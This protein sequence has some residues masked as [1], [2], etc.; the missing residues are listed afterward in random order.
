MNLSK[1][2]NRYNLLTKAILVFIFFLLLN[3]IFWRLSFTFYVW[4]DWD[5][6]RPIVN[7]NFN[8]LAPHNEHFLPISKLLYLIQVKLFGAHPEIMQLVNIFLH[9]ITA[10][11][12]GYLVW[13]LFRNKKYAFLMALIFSIHPFQSDNL[14]Y[15]FQLQIILNMMFFLTSLICIKLFFDSNLK[16][17]YAASLVFTFLQSY[18]FG[19]GLALHIPILIFFYIY[20][21]K[22]YSLKYYLPYFFL[23]LLNIVVYKIYETSGF[24][25]TDLLNTHNLK[26]ISD[27][28]FN[29]IFANWGRVI[30]IKVDNIFTFLLFVYTI[31]ASAITL[32]ISHDIKFKTKYWQ[33]IIF[34]VIFFGSPF[35]IIS[36]SRYKFGIAQGYSLR[37]GYFYIIPICILFFTISDYILQNF[38]PINNFKKHFNKIFLF[39]IILILAGSYIVDSREKRKIENI[40]KYNFAEMQ[41]FNDDRNY[42]PDLSQ[43]HPFQT[44]YELLDTMKKLELISP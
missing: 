3:I 43:L 31:V 25:F 27:Y 5:W 24:S 20:K 14:L 17:F 44:K 29:A 23:F 4:D 41:K 30:G 12:S 16:I 2:W 40:G 38:K 9:S 6:L 8:L 37:Y 11:L 35:L 22:K 36:L 26:Q 33:N 15:V 10:L 1:I 42:N 28:F 13:L 39:L 32:M 34:S 18:C 7:G 19:A 21:N